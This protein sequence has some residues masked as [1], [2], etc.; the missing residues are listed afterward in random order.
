MRFRLDRFS[1]DFWIWRVLHQ[2]SGIPYFLAKSRNGDFWGE[3]MGHVEVGCS[4][5][6]VHDALV[7]RISGVVSSC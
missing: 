1:K 5:N 4:Y 6:Q 7:E 3:T 2:E